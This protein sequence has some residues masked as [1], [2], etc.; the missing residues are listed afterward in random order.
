[1]SVFRVRPCTSLLEWSVIEGENP[2]FGMDN[3]CFCD[4]LSK[5]RVVWECS[6]KWVVNSI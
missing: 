6:S 1:R 5:S 2:V 3:W 4:A